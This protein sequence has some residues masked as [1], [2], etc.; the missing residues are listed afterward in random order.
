MSQTELICSSFCIPFVT[1]SLPK[2]ETLDS[3][4][5]HLPLNFT[6]PLSFIHSTPSTSFK[7]VDEDNHLFNVGL[8]VTVSSLAPCCVCLPFVNPHLTVICN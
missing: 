5:F 3:A 7:S 2:L 8:T 1:W 4:F 6:I